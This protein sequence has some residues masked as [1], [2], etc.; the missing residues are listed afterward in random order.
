ML[1]L[2][3]TPRIFLL[4][5]WCTVRKWRDEMACS[6]DAVLKQLEHPIFLRLPFP[7]SWERI[8]FL[9]VVA[10]CMSPW[11]CLLLD[12]CLVTTL[13]VLVTVLL[14]AGMLVA[15]KCRV[16]CVTLREPRVTT[17][18]VSGLSLCL[19]VMAVCACCPGPQGRQ[20]LLSLMV[21]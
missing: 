19:C 7:M 14:G 12:I 17:S 13:Y 16:R 21:L 3:E 9:W 18:P 20:T 10:W 5:L 1:T 8:V 15:M 11:V 2:I 4:T 6:G